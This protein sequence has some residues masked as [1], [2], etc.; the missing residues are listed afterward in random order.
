MRW[1][2][3]SLANRSLSLKSQSVGCLIDFPE[4]AKL[5]TR[6][7]TYVKNIAPMFEDKCVSCHEPGGIG[8][9]PFDQF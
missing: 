6:R 2:R 5:A 3:S 8:P 9:M 7:S 1:I 4:R